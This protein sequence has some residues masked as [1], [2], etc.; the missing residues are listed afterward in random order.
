MMH[1]LEWEDNG[2]QNQV[3]LIQRNFINSML[4]KN[5]YFCEVMKKHCHKELIMT[6]KDY[7]GFNNSAKC[8]ICD[9]DYVD[10]NV[11]VRDHCHIIG[12]YRG[13]AQRDCNNK[14][15]WNHKIP[16]VFHSIMINISLCKN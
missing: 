15:T 16:I 3:S 6:K 11:K 14:V 4:R 8:W 7:E 13:S 5:K 10:G 12:K 9:D 2:K 1:I